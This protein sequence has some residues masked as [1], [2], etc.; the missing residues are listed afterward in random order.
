MA[1]QAES[2]DSQI[3]LEDQIMGSGVHDPQG[4]P[5]LRSPG[6]PG[7]GTGLLETE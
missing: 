4:P 3:L 1:S 6:Q 5:A 7:A 2:G